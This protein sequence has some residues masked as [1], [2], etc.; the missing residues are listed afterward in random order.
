[1]SSFEYQILRLYGISDRYHH[2]ATRCGDAVF[3]I[4]LTTGDAP[5]ER[6][7]STSRPAAG[8]PRSSA[9]HGLVDPDPLTA[10]TNR[11]SKERPLLAR[12][13][14]ARLIVADQRRPGALLSSE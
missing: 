2:A 4:D 7:G 14:A 1:M 5:R 12:A 3:R 10:R 6:T 9:N 8:P 13:V 11:P